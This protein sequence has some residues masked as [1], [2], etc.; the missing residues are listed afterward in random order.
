[1]NDFEASLLNVTFNGTVREIPKT[2]TK[3]HQLMNKTPR[4]SDKQNER[5]QM[6]REKEIQPKNTLIFEIFERMILSG[7]AFACK[8][9]STDETLQHEPDFSILPFEWLKYTL[10]ICTNHI[11]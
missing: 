8:F 9:Y 5:N 2:G 10:C 4:P 7:L 3:P 11:S 6:R 1:M